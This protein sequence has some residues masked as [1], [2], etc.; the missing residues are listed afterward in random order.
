MSQ[1]DELMIPPGDEEKKQ[2]KS[3]ALVVQFR[4]LDKKAEH[5]IKAWNP[6]H[7]DVIQYRPMA[8][9]HVEESHIRR[10]A[11][12]IVIVAFLLFVIWASFAPIDQGVNGQGTV[13]VSGYRKALQHPTG[14]VVQDILVKEGDVVKEGDILI[15]I[16]PLQAQADLSAI[17]LQYINALVSEARLNAERKGEV[18]ITWPAELDRWGNDPKVKEAKQIQQ[19]LFDTR[20]TEIVAVIN[21]RR[22]QLATLVSEAANNAALAQEGYVSKAQSNQ[23]M[24]SKVDA[25]LQLNQL[26]AAYY[27]D[28]D[29]QLATI[30]QTRDALRDKLEAVSFNRDLTSI[31]A[32]VSGTVIGLKLNTKG[33]TVPAGQVLGEIVPSESAL[34]VDAKVPPTIIDRVAVGESADLRFTTFNA[35]STPVITGTVI[36]VNPDKITAGPGEQGGDYYLAKVEASKEGL[37]ELGNLKILA[38]MP[39]DVIFK[40]GERTFLSYLLKSITDRTARAFKDN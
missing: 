34:V 39:V 11:A 40:T 16:N 10:T 29:G 22:A 23:I 32:P 19:K 7:P 18:K 31:R 27:K 20:R 21:G 15:R 33:G 4:E 9:V 38:G 12:K 14:G 26:Q 13:V 3:N 25:E 5:W 6:Y 28:I 2:S 17:E 24:R 36:L 37:V 1:Q 35:N 8:P 30:Q